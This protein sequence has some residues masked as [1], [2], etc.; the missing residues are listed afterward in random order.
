VPEGEVLEMSWYGDQ[1]VQ[2]ELGG[3]FHSG[4]LSV[5]AS[6]VGRVAPA[7]RGSRSAADRM[8]LALEL[9]ADQAFD[10]LLTGESDFA[11]LPTVL[12][13]LASGEVPALC[14]T[15]RYPEEP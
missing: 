9:L 4:R 14:H 1:P 2:L 10:A 5:R 12:A 8:A 15:I 7:R 6:Q 3:A 13:G 11:E